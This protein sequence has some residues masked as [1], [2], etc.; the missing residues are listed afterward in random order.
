M[1]TSSHLPSFISE[2][3][4]HFLVALGPTLNV[5]G[6]ISEHGSTAVLLTAVTGQSKPRDNVGP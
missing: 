1:S 4:K 3:S 2:E 5:E 6:L